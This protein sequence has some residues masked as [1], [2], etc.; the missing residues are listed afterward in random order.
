MGSP[1][2]RLAL[3]HEA[4]ERGLALA[5][6]DDD[7]MERRRMREKLADV[8]IGLNTWDTWQAV[9]ESAC[10]HWQ[11]R[12]LALR[13]WECPPMRSSPGATGHGRYY[14]NQPKAAALRQQLLD[15]NL[16]IFEPD[17]IRALGEA[18]AKRS[19]AS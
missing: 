7:P 3:D 17:P 13:P 19:A 1:L 11:C 14:Y 16:S 8:E 9:A 15:A 6:A 18:E 4:L 2:D 12:N 10:Y 5:L